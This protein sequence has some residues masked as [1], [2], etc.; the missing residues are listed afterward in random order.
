[1]TFHSVGNFIL[2]NVTHSYFSEGLAE[3]TN[4]H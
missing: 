4:E 2:P 1:M 3:T